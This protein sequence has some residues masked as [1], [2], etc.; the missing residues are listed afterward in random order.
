MEA[1]KKCLQHRGGCIYFMI[2]DDDSDLAD[3]HF[4]NFLSESSGEEAEP[5]PAEALTQ[6][7]G[8]TKE[9]KLTIRSARG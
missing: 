6:K 8:R 7:G 2:A 3:S 1:N 9:P 4:V 5:V